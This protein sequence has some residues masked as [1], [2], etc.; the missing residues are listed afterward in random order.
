MVLIDS[1]QIPFLENGNWQLEQGIILR[2]VC[3][4]ARML[5]FEKLLLMKL[6]N[7]VKE[8]SVRAPFSMIVCKRSSG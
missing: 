3:V 1:N 7:E 8:I 4:G 5:V 2:S 6:T